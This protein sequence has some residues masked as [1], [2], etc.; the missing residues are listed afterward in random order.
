M[1]TYRK[2][3]CECLQFVKYTDGAYEDSFD[4]GTLDR[5]FKN[6][7]FVDTGYHAVSAYADFKK[8]FREIQF[9]VFSNGG[10]VLE[11]GTAFLLDGHTRKDYKTYSNNIRDGVYYC[12]ELSI[13]PNV[14]SDAFVYNGGSWACTLI[15]DTSIPEETT[16][17]DILRGKEGGDESL[18][19]AL[20]AWRIGL[21]ALK[22]PAPLVFRL[23]VSGKGL[24]PRFKLLGFREMPIELRGINWVYHLMHGR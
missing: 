3:G 23:P 24:H 4:L 1:C 6:I 21:S 13:N 14:C 17:S 9:K 10:A 20:G 22:A 7:A 18:T 8:R 19:T 12:N 2:D 5:V 16:V 11:F 15:A